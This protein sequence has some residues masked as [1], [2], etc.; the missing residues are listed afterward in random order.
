MAVAAA[1]MLAPAA[2]GG[3]QT[4]DDGLYLCELNESDG[5]A[6]I[7]NYYTEETV[8]DAPSYPFVGNY[9]TPT[10]LTFGGQS[11]R[12]TEIDLGL[13]A[14]GNCTS[15]TF[16]DGLKK[17]R[18]EYV[19]CPIYDFDLHRY[20][21]YFSLSN[22][23]LPDGLLELSFGLPY[24]LS[25]LPTDT[26]FT[27]KNG[28][29]IVDGYVIGFS[30]AYKENMPESI[31][32]DLRGMDIRG[33]AN[34]AFNSYEED[35][36][37]ITSIT[38]P[39]TVNSLCPGAF[40]GC[41]NLKRVKFEGDA[42]AGADGYVSFPSGTKIYVKPGTT[43]WGDVPGT[44]HGATVA[45][46]PTDVNVTFQFNYRGGGSGTTKTIKSDEPVLP[47]APEVPTRK[48]FEFVGWFTASTGGEQIDS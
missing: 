4:S 48:G 46:E 42:P 15:V 21:G 39:S 19:D 26:F 11:Y 37:R 1:A 33:V 30:N 35:S 31:D 36:S 40:T 47:S 27:I 18:I 23:K 28:L 8:K 6:T 10:T 12:V 2:R 5:T 44:W 41:T 20:T 9:V 13:V 34:G 17:I 16:S 25:A 38:L 32:L 14:L 22:V 3:Q 24:E 45:Y 7:I 43:G 29:R